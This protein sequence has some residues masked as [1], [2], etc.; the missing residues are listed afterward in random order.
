MALH[1]AIAAVDTLKR[2][3]CA[4]LRLKTMRY[5]STSASSAAVAAP[6]EG[7]NNRPV[8]KMKV[9]EIEKLIGISGMRSVAHPLAAVSRTRISHSMPTGWTTRSRMEYASTATPAHVMPTT[10]I[11]PR[12]GDRAGSWAIGTLIGGPGGSLFPDG[13]RGESA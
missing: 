1:I 3:R 9:S 11:V 8:E 13:A 7:P 12:P 5:D 6:A 10:Y 4:V 2:T